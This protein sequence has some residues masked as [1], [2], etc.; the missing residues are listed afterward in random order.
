[1]NHRCVYHAFVVALLF[2]MLVA[3]SKAVQTASSTRPVQ[4]AQSRVEPA[5]VL[6]VIGVYQGALPASADKRPWWAQCQ[7]A[8]RAA[9]DNAPI[10]PNECTA[11]QHQ[12]REHRTVT[13]NV[14]DD[15]SPI[16]LGLMAYEPVTWKIEVAPGVNLRKVILA[17][18][19][20]QR[21][22]GVA[23]TQIDVYTHERSE[24]E[25]CV[26]KGDYF[27]SYQHVPAEMEAAT[28]LKASSF[29][30]NYTGGRYVVFKGMQ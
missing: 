9:G 25:R 8:K 17:G 12:V 19:H 20:Q 27:Y 2:C 13:V 14:S 11:F 6:H 22:E 26:Q 5:T 24:C 3:C 21:I 4:N 30:G 15:A 1:M 10:K 7:A 18:Y 23:G 16:V 28:G 29:Q